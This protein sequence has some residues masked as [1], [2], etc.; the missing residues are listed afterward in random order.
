[1][2]ASVFGAVIR[3]PIDFLLAGLQIFWQRPAV[4]AD[5]GG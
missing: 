2:A 5:T 3:Y 1:M 4:D